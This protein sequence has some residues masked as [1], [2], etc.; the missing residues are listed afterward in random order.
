ML[1]SNKARFWF[2]LSLFL[3]TFLRKQKAVMVAG[4]QRLFMSKIS[5]ANDLKSSQY[6]LVICANQRIETFCIANIQ[7]HEKGDV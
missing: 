5:I 6:C 2:A 3:L 1:L 7:T 4:K